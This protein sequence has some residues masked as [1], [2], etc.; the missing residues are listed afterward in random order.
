MG[1]SQSEESKKRV[2]ISKSE[3]E[4][5]QF[6]IMT[7]TDI[8]DIS[9]PVR[10]NDTPAY[11]LRYYLSKDRKRIFI[12]T[13]ALGDTKIVT[14]RFN[15]DLC[16]HIKDEEF[17][18]YLCLIHD[19]IEKELGSRLRYNTYETIKLVKTNSLKSTDIISIDNV[20]ITRK[21]SVIKF[22]KSCL[23]KYLIRLL[24]HYLI[25]KSF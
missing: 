14:S 22:K 6:N 17:R 11:D 2:V 21:L 10:L 1:S 13:S 12:P 25:F 15:K 7:T 20:T 8:V 18:N 3:R 5:R 19:T 23:I 4:A 9:H 24:Q 16:I